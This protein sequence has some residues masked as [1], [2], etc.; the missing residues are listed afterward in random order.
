M[1][2]EARSREY[3]EARIRAGVLEQGT[4]D[5][6]RGAGVGARMDAEGLV[7]HGSSCSSTASASCATANARLA[8]GTPQ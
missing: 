2:L 3:C 1:I 4:V 6:L 7:H 5:L 8:A